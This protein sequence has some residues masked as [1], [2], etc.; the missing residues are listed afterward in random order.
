MSE[1]LLQEEQ[2]VEFHFTISQLLLISGQ[3]RHVRDDVLTSNILSDVISL[4][5]VSLT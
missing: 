5:K 2:T 1:K 4:T 3:A